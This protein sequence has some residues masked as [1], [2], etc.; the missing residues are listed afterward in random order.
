M[1]LLGLTTAGAL[2]MYFIPLAAQTPLPLIL[3]GVLV[4][5]INGYCEELLGRGLYVKAFPRQPIWGVVYPAARF[6]L[7]HVAPQLVYP[8][9]EGVG[10]LVESAFG[11]GLVYGA[12]AHQ[13]GAMK[14][15]GLSHSVNGVLA[16]GGALAPSLLRLVT[17]AGRGP[18]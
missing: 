15:V 12:V 5:V 9:P 10:A 16:F 6:A 13:T 3:I 18:G 11:L 14:W 17:A 2:S 7:W 1:L 4:A 8:A